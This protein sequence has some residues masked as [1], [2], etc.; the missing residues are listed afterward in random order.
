MDSTFA[1][2]ADAPAEGTKEDRRFTRHK[3]DMRLKLSLVQGDGKSA[4]AFGRANTL[5]YGG[6]GAYVPCSIHV[7]ESVLIDLI[8]P[9]S[10]K[11]VRVKAVVRSCE[12]FRYGLEFTELPEGVRS[13]I[14]KVCENLPLSR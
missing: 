13:T 6:L 2:P 1:S 3:V 14:S 10:T 12:G 7:G 4:S 5:S 11:E 8:F 9:G